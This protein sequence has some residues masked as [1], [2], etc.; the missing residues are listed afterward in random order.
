MLRKCKTVSH[1]AHLAPTSDMHQANRTLCMAEDLL[2]KLKLSLAMGQGF[3]M[4]SSEQCN[5]TRT[6]NHDCGGVDDRLCL[7]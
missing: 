6:H 7:L 2:T 5:S 4:Q 1:V 3:E